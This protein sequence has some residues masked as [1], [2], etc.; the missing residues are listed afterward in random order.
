MVPKGIFDPNKIETKVRD[1]PPSLFVEETGIKDEGLS[2]LPPTAPKTQIESPLPK[3]ANRELVELEQKYKLEQKA[4]KMREDEIKN[5]EQKLHRITNQL[6]EKE[7]S[8]SKSELNDDRRYN[9]DEQTQ[10][11]RDLEEKY[12]LKLEQMKKD[13]ELKQ[14]RME[15]EYEKKLQKDDRSK[16]PQYIEKVDRPRGGY[17]SQLPY[18]SN[19]LADPSYQH[20][21]FYPPDDR[22]RLIGHSR[23][24]D[25]DL[26]I[27]PPPPQVPLELPTTF[28]L[29]RDDEIAFVKLGIKDEILKSHYYEEPQLEIER[30]NP[31]Q[32]SDFT[33][34][35]I[36]FKPPL[37]MPFGQCVPRRMYFKFNF[38]TFQDT[39]TETCEVKDPDG[40]N[41]MTRELVPGQQYLLEKLGKQKEMRDFKSI[42]TQFSIDGSVS[43]IHDE[44]IHFYKYLLE[45]EL[46]IDIYDADS[47]LHYGTCRVNLR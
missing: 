40:K 3:Y 2:A 45:R 21:S 41:D 47:L 25:D 35:F 16:S 17:S 10:H 36:A 32:A 11:L 1:K 43:K 27:L 46:S 18:A 34:R 22:S 9:K 37:A 5:L 15:L 33:F 31:L 29:S 30:K 12:Q 8:K 14:E 19:Y 6:Y 23:K 26:K 39:I 4:S 44:N 20:P 38:F 42:E 13:F 28:D 24:Y 7:S